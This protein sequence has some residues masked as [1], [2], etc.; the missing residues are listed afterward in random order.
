MH[1]MGVSGQW[2][3]V[4]TSLAICALCVMACLMPGRA[5]AACASGLRSGAHQ[6]QADNI[7]SVRVKQREVGVEFCGH[8]GS[9]KWMRLA[10]TDGRFELSAV[11]LASM[12]S[13]MWRL[14]ARADSANTGG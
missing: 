12:L 4:L 11:A 2:S 6:L 5:L 7:V 13:I 14:Q 9:P 10:A 1:A 8:D 3:P